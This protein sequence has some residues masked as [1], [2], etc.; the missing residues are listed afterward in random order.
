MS[1]E[2]GEVDFSSGKITVASG[3]KIILLQSFR[4]LGK[5]ALLL[6]TAATVV[7]HRFAPWIFLEH[8]P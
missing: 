6:L 4:P 2:A 5:N 3:W 7:A 8:L 1:S